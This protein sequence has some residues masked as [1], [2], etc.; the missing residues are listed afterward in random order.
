LWLL[1]V[2][3]KFITYFT[4]I[5]TCRLNFKKGENYL[6]VYDSTFPKSSILFEEVKV[7]D[8]TYTLPKNGWNLRDIPFKV[9]T[10]AIKEEVKK[11]W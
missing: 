1:K 5:K 9:D 10:L 11:I 3:N 8:S 7:T 6:I 2:F 4:A